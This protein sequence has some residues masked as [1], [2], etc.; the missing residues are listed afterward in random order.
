MQ[1][2]IVYC[3]AIIIKV[4][5]LM[6]APEAKNIKILTYFNDQEMTYVSLLDGII[7]RDL[8]TRFL[9]VDEYDAM[10][11]WIMKNPERYQSLS[12]ESLADMVRSH[13]E[14]FA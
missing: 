1:T 2:A 5:K 11:E 3:I 8:V 13:S 7:T 10:F 14:S 6:H 12:Q 9:S 4:H